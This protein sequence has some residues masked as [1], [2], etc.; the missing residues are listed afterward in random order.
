MNKNQAFLIGADMVVRSNDALGRSIA[1]SNRRLGEKF[2]SISKEE[3]RSR[4]RVNITLEEYE[5]MKHELSSL[6]NEV[7]RLRAILGNIGIPIDK[8]II[9]G[10]I[11]TCTMDDF[12]HFGRTNYRVEFEITHW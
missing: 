7:R 10:S 2:E 3:I 11:R 6:E 12:R 5:R 9:P 8:N 4:D 1:D